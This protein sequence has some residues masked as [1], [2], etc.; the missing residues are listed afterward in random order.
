MLSRLALPK[1]FL[2]KNV[3]AVAT[4]A[5]VNTPTADIIATNLLDADDLLDSAALLEF[6]VASEDLELEFALAFALA[7]ALRLASALFLLVL[8]PAFTLVALDSFALEPAV[9]EPLGLESGALLS[10]ALLV[11]AGFELESAP[12]LSCVLCV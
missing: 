8:A 11:L 7:F 6:L 3:A 2:T 5:V 10:L 9:L 12:F 4:I 1:C